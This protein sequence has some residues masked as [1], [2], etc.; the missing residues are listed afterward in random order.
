MNFIRRFESLISWVDEPSKEL[1]EAMKTKTYK[2]NSLVWIWN[3]VS[4]HDIFTSKINYDG[5]VN[6]KP[7]SGDF[8]D[9]SPSEELRLEV[10]RICKNFGIKR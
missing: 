10:D 8:K 2:W 4:S 6:Q 1:I 9:K 5:S 3:G 7:F